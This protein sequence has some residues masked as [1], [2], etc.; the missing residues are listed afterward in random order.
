MNMISKL[1]RIFTHLLNVKKQ[2]LLI[3]TLSSLAHLQAQNT[4]VPSLL[5]SYNIITWNNV[6][7]GSEI[8]GRA[9]IGGSLT[10]NN[11][12]QIGANSPI[13]I[14]QTDYSLAV[15]GGINSN[16]SLNVQSGSILS[17]LPSSAQFNMN[18]H[19]TVVTGQAA[20]NSFAPAASLS[21]IQSEF[22]TA[23]QYW[24]TL[25]PT[26]TVTT[27]PNN[28]TISGN[29]SACSVVDLTAAQLDSAH[30]I[31]LSANGSNILI[32]NVTGSTIL[33]NAN[34]LGASNTAATKVI[35]NFV[36]ATSITFST[37]VE[38]SIVAPYAAVT[39]SNGFDGCLVASSL[40][41]TGAADATLITATSSI[42]LPASTPEPNSLIMLVGGLCALVLFR[43]FR[44][45]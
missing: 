40:T 15:Y 9:L 24:D 34:F 23:S 16:G 35:F 27:D 21:T 18:S 20:W 10:V 14:S 11:S 39:T 7:L 28:F 44:I 33:L 8:Q 5:G 25:T 26:G 37:K 4:T 6:Q 13:P 17:R 45:Q 31:T 36:D 41:T 32:I 1:K 42:P 38:G 29:G 30:G 12:T 43:R 3:L 19:G 2:A 22:K